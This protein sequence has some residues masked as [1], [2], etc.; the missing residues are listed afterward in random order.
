M[1]EKKLRG[2][3]DRIRVGLSIIESE[4]NSIYSDNEEAQTN[5]QLPL[6]KPCAGCKHNK[7]ILTD[8]SKCLACV[9]SAVDCFEPRTVSDS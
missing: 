2:R 6:S 1:D 7:R 3:I 4:I 9:W 8:D 5:A